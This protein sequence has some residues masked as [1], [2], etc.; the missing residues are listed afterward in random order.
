MV[1]S[2]VL[3]GVVAS[4][5]PTTGTALAAP[6]SNSL[7]VRG[8]RVFDGFRTV[9]R[10]S[11]L[12]L[13]GLIAAVGTEREVAAPR[14]IQV[15]DGRDRTVI[16]GLVDAHV[17]TDDEFR[18]DA[19]RFGVTTELDMFGDPTQ[20]PAAKRRRRS[21]R[22]TDRADLWSAGIGVTVPG[23]H[24]NIPGWDYPRLTGDPERFV[25]D[26][27]REGSDYIKIVVESGGDPPLPT[28]RSDQVRATVAAAHRRGKLAVAH[29]ERI[30]H[31]WTA[32]EAGV[33]GLVHVVIDTDLD[34]AFVR[35]VRRSGAFVVP[36][37]PV[38]DCGADADDLLADPLVRPY[39]SEAQL[40]TLQTRRPRCTPDWRRLSLANAGR[41]RDAGVPILAGT[42]APLPGTANGAS[43]LTELGALV[44]AGLSPEQALAAATGATA[45]AFGLSDRG[46]VRPGKRADL[47][48]VNGDPTTD[49]AAVRDIA[50]IVKNGYPVN[51]TPA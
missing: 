21:L 44:E 18:N 26:R 42:D 9:E 3:G 5:G 19:L 31:A 24:P 33:D 25:A 46:R 38:I 22:R 15:Y 2:L 45:S 1:T 37:V 17:H 23:G 50:A 47:V 27:V 49:I 29:A 8:T 11:V 34:D 43:L 14:G 28:L 30:E 32:I 40:Y 16:P 10:A 20:L 35:A 6:A 41:L 7:L 36:T 13:G 48:L 4:L 12:V 39:L 51:R